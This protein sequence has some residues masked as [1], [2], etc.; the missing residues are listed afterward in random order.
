MNAFLQLDREAGR[1]E[2][3]D[4][5][6]RRALSM[7]PPG[8]ERQAKMT[9]EGIL[10]SRIRDARS[11]PWIGSRL[12]GDGFPFE[13]SFCTADDRLR[14]TAEPGPPSLAP[15]ERLLIACELIERLD[16]YCLPSEVLR[17]FKALQRGSQ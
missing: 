17:T 15:Q 10:A 1:I 8:V 6:I 7:F 11:N 4:P 9:A 12:T 5:S 13:L 3:L 2:G 14:F 16:A